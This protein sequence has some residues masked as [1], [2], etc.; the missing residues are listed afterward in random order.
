[1]TGNMV[2]I[3]KLDDKPL[4]IGRKFLKNVKFNKI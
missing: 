4:K 1:M 3:C 2:R